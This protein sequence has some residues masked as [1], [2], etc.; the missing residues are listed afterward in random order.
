MKNRKCL[1]SKKGSV[2]AGTGTGPKAGHF[3]TSSLLSEVWRSLAH[4]THGFRD[5][6]VAGR[7]ETEANTR[8]P[9]Q[10]FGV[11]SPSTCLRAGQVYQNSVV[12]SDHSR[13]GVRCRS[14]GT[15]DGIIHYKP[16]QCYFALHFAQDAVTGSVFD[17][18]REERTDCDGSRQIWGWGS[19]S[20][21]RDVAVKTNEMVE[22]SG[23]RHQGCKA[24]LSNR[25]RQRRHWRQGDPSWEPASSCSAGRWHRPVQRFH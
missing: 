23:Q 13:P 19:F 9:Q 3:G 24:V 2:E 10:W 25:A 22:V 16:F 6:T 17:P 18:D 12:I 15:L 5:H 11:A 14:S 4:C 21:S 7:N 20:L 8:R 1:W